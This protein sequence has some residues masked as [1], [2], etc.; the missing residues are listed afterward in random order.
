[1]TRQTASPLSSISL[2][3]FSRGAREI[4]RMFSE[5]DGDLSPEYQRGSVWSEDQR[6][7]LV[8]SWLMGLPVPAVVVNDRIFGPW[9]GGGPNGTPEGGFCYAVIDGKQ[10]IETAVAWFEGEL[11]VPASWFSA[12]DVEETVTTEDGEYVTFSGL[13]RVAQRLC[14]TRFQLPTVEARLATLQEEAEMYV[15]LNGSGVPQEESDMLNAAR[16]AGM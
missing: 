14:A 6:I 15:L 9:A 8:K 2:Q 4:A 12:E 10:R 7:G 16:V 13:T 5:G 11:A 3:S 1:M